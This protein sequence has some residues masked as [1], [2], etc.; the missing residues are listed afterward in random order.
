MALM[1]SKI[2]W[3]AFIQRQ[4]QPP[5]RSLVT[6]LV[7]HFDEENA[8][9]ALNKLGFSITRLPSEEGLL[10]H[11]NTTLLIGAPEGSEHVIWRTLEE[12]CSSPISKA[13]NQPISDLSI[14]NGTEIF[15]F[16]VERFIE[17]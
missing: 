17:L 11:G 4:R 12:L 10:Q 16:E 7:P 6:V 8:I 2:N 3:S 5:I 15:S 14:Q 13:A 1:E 9:N